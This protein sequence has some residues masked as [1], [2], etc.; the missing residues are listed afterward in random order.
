MRLTARSTSTT[1]GA[2]EESEYPV[3]RDS[4]M[5]VPMPKNT[6]PTRLSSPP[7]TAAVKANTRKMSKLFGASV[8]DGAMRTP[9][10]APTT[11][12]IAQ[13]SPSM[14]PT[15]TPESRATSGLKA[16]ARMASP[17]DVR[18]SSSPRPITSTAVTAMMSRS[19]QEIGHTWP[20]TSSPAFEMGGPNGCGLPPQIM[21]A[22]A[23][24]TIRTP[25]VAMIAPVV[26]ILR[27][28]RSTNA[29]TMSPRMAPATSAAARPSSHDPV[30]SRTASATNVVAIA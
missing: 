18:V 11:P 10:T 30:D 12:A 19:Y 23:C 6:A 25:N 14:R 13:P 20:K 24:S 26:S 17:T 1:T 9:A 22:A 2:L 16:E 7:S 27:T 21:A 8:A 3:T 28:G 5:P 29:C 4:T 15:R